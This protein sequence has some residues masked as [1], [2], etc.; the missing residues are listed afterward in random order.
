MLII[1]DTHGRHFW[2]KPVREALGH[3]RIVFLGDYVDPYRDEPIGRSQAVRRFEEIIELKRS[4]PDEVVLLLGNH[5]LQYIDGRMRAGRYDA[6]HGEAIRA[7]VEDNAR[8]FQIAYTD[9]PYLFTHAG[10]L[11]GWVRRHDAEL[12]PVG[13]TP[14]DIPSRLNGMWMDAERRA[15]L[16]PLLSEIP[17]SRRGLCLHG[18]PVWA[19]ASDMRTDGPE[20]DGFLQVFGHTLQDGPPLLTPYFACVDCRRA[21]RLDGQGLL[22]PVA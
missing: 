6:V 17:V 15:R 5:D 21:F 1:P 12:L 2:C 22:H 7:L 19:D 8:L 13:G 14:R 16:L 3:E 20:I 4:R 11:G 18:S 10:L 9:G